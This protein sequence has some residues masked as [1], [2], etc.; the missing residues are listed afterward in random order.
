MERI[1]T[2][3]IGAGSAPFGEPVQQKNWAEERDKHEK[4]MPSA[5]SGVMKTPDYHRDA[6]DAKQQQS[7]GMLSAEA[8]P[9]VDSPKPFPR[10]ESGA[11]WLQSK[12]GGGGGGGGGGLGG[13]GGGGFGRD[14]SVG[15]SVTMWFSCFPADRQP[16]SSLLMVQ[17]LGAH[18]LPASSLYHRRLDLKRRGDRYLYTLVH[19]FQSSNHIRR[20]DRVCKTRCGRPGPD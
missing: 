18:L 1:G 2:V 5:S 7:S 17:G 13:R 10:Q 8:A 15:A 16:T 20:L 6:S 9:A 19:R 14:G 3:L 12:A 4:K 11:P